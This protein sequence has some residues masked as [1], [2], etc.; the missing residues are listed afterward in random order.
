MI[1]TLIHNI[2]M[3]IFHRQRKNV[4]QLPVNEGRLICWARHK[5]LLRLQ[6]LVY[7]RVFDKLCL[8]ANE[9]NF[10]QS[11]SKHHPSE[12]RKLRFSPLVKEVQAT[13]WCILT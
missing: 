5:I 11:N 10:L 3:M 8:D 6:V 9:P 7:A 2:A 4:R 12:I 13:H 1:S